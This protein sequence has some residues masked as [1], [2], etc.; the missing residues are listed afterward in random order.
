MADQDPELLDFR[1]AEES[2]AARRQGSVERNNAGKLL[3]KC[4]CHPIRVRGAFTNAGQVDSLR[5]NVVSSPG[6]LDGAQ[7]V[8]LGF[9]VA[10]TVGAPGEGR[11]PIRP[12]AE[13][14]L[15]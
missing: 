4:E 11:R 3:W 9:R 6:L 14:A 12:F 2:G 8:V 13:Q 1:Q 15:A 7:N 10:L 5:M